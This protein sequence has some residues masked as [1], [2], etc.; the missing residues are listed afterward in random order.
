MNRIQ[1]FEIIEN[2]KIAKDVY[3]MVLKGPTNWIQRPGQF[4]NITI[5]DAYLKRP[6]SISDYDD[7]T[8]TIIYKVVGFGTNQ[9]SMLSTH[10]TIEALVDLGNGFEIKAID[11][12][13]L[14]GGG[15]GVPPLYKLC[16]EL[17]AKG[18]KVHVV[19][20]FTNYQDVFYEEEF[21]TLTNNVYVATNDGSYGEKGFVTNVI[22]KYALDNLY[23][24]SCG[25]EV[26][27]KALMKMSK[28][29]GQL[30]FEA[31]M[32]CGFGACMGCSCKTIT[33]YKRI[34]VEGPV[35]D[36]TEVLWKD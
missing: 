33:G 1:T 35:M 31:R 12:V 22:E 29:S 20:G 8:L 15:V 5:K 6:I 28:A 25:P 18:I 32:G 16:K 36:S 21:K 17:V 10:D 23:Y 2:Q 9:L 7:E 19:L 34:C 24:Y 14:V 11:E 13:L 27:L 26:M 3:K 4:I 30:S